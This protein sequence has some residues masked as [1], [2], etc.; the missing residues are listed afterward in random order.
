MERNITVYSIKEF[1]IPSSSL[2]P[3]N[4]NNYRLFFQLPNGTGYSEYPEGLYPIKVKIASNSLRPFAAYNG[5][6]AISDVVF[7]VEVRSTGTDVPGIT[8]LGT[9][10]KW[11]Y[12]NPQWNFWYVFT[13]TEKMASPEFWIDFNDIR[14]NYT[15]ANQ[16]SNVGLY[17]KIEFFGDAKNLSYG[18]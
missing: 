9:T 2:S 11:D 12:Q 15:A 1:R 6:T 7:G 5:G 14:T 17:M 8:S 16:P 13:I 18:N 10:G 3:I 4:S